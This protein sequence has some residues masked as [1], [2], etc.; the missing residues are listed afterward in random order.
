VI[1]RDVPFFA[2]VRADA[3]PNLG[4]SPSMPRQTGWVT[5]ASEPVR[6]T[7]EATLT[8]LICL[9]LRADYSRKVAKDFPKPAQRIGKSFGVARY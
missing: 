3:A 7:G 1:P 2:A 6:R 5:N 4:H 8:S 9:V